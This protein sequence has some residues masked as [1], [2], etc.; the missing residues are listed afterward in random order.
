MVLTLF[1]L[2]EK[3]YKEI[4]QIVD[5]PVGTVKTYMHRGRSELRIIMLRQRGK[6]PLTPL[7]AIGGKSVNGVQVQEQLTEYLQHPSTVRRVNALNRHLEQCKACREVCEIEKL[8][9]DTLRQPPQLNPPDHFAARL[10]D[11]L[12]AV[13]AAKARAT[14]RRFLVSLPH[15]MAAAL[16]LIG[17][18]EEILG[19]RLFVSTTTTLLHQQLGPLFSLVRQM[20]AIEVTYWGDW[21]EVMVQVSS[22]MAHPNPA[23]AIGLLLLGLA[24]IPAAYFLPH[25]DSS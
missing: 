9:A 10:R 15:V 23:F 20:T 19:P 5:M 7:Q 12:Q 22:K 13:V 24:S 4:A 17:L 21:V 16:F 8:L 1:Y 11:Q 18:W 14:S 3:R 6:S 2:E 25:T